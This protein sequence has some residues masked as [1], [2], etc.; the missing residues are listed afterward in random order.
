LSIRG[1]SGRS[2]AKLLAK[3]FDDFGGG[4]YKASSA[5]VS[6]SVL[7]NNLPKY[8]IF[9]IYSGDDY[10]LE[11]NMTD[12]HEEQFILKNKMMEIYKNNFLQI[13]NF[14]Q[15]EYYSIVNSDKNLDS[16]LH[17]IY[18]YHGKLIEN[19]LAEDIINTKK[20][21]DFY[22]RQQQFQQQP[23]QQQP[24]QQKQQQ[25]FQQQQFQQQQFQQQ[26]FQ[27]QQP[28]LGL[29]SPTHEFIP[30][31]QQQSLQQ[32]SLS[33]LKS[34]THEFIPKQQQLSGLKVPT[35]EFI[36]TRQFDFK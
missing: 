29:K 30:K 4:H 36:P 26:Q 5:G 11:L 15:T 8:K 28:S 24:F 10:N 25:Q 33:G 21:E 2:D 17:N 23:F 1:I 34:P 18:E 6:I 12:L 35:R 9:N 31:H 16:M 32:Q 20:M 7:S 22:K 19:A 3:T 13:T 14:N 27:Q